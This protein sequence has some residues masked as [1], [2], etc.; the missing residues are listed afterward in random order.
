MPLLERGCSQIPCENTAICK[1]I[2]I[3]K[4][5]LQKFVLC[6]VRQRNVCQLDDSVQSLI[7]HLVVVLQINLNPVLLC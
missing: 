7:Q 6:S 4:A 1:G 2:L 5:A 3:E